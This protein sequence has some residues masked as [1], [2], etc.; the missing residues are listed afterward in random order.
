MKAGILAVD[1]DGTIAHDNYPGIGPLRQGARRALWE[2]KA[3]GW[4]IIIWTCRC[5]PYLDEMIE[6][7][8]SNHVPFDVI[9]DHAPHNKARY[10]GDA[11]K[12]FA[13]IYID[14]RAIG[15]WTWA[16]VLQRVKET[17]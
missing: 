13:D 2:A 17:A 10:N 7:L 8:R 16:D 15:G 3:R 11:R 6:F 1:F 9:N 4:T 12:V 14:D 5:G